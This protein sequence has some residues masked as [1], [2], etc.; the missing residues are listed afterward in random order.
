[1]KVIVL[2]ISKNN[3]KSFSRYSIFDLENSNNDE[4]DIAKYILNSMHRL[5]SNNSKLYLD[6]KKLKKK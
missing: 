5:Q 6:N 1:M 3:I 4:E 2:S